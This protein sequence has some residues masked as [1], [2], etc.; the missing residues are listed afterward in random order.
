MVK[1]VSGSDFLN[2]ISVQEKLVVQFHA[3]WCG[4]CRSFS[5]HFT[6]AAASDRSSAQW[7]RVNVDELDQ[8]TLEDY[9]IM[10]IPR[11]IVFEDGKPVKDLTSRTKLGLL[12]EINA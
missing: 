6:A 12:E 1:D 4:P 7:S 11:V 2:E 9:G 5:P 10:S 3:D 8:Q